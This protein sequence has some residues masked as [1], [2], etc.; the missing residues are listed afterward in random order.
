MLLN[1]PGWHVNF[2]VWWIH[3]KPAYLSLAYGN[4]ETVGK[5]AKSL[6]R[7]HFTWLWFAIAKWEILLFKHNVQC[8]LC[9]SRHKHGDDAISRKK[10]NRR[11]WTVE[12]E[13]STS[14]EKRA[15]RKVGYAMQARGLKVAQIKFHAKL[16][17]LFARHL[18]R[19]W[20]SCIYLATC[21]LNRQGDHH[22]V[23]LVS[24]F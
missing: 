5:T 15:S 8:C 9:K 20:F 10:K 3:K 23:E 22:A 21:W 2:F 14:E 11:N 16:I 19:N 6:A 18:L 13:A 1:S 7:K 4:F 17:D 24:A 12:K